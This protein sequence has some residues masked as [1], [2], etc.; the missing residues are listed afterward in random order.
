MN[1]E[2][3]H[4]KKVLFEFLQKEAGLQIYLTGDLDDFFW[5]KT[6]WYAL[7]ENDEIKSV[8][9]LYSGMMPPTLLCFQRKDPE[10]A[11]LLLKEI[12]PLLPCRF[13]AHLG[14]GFADVFGSE[15]I[16]E[17]YGVNYKMV[18]HK[19]IHFEIVND[20][21][22]LGIN[23]LPRLL[24]LYSV[25]YPNNWFD[26][27]MLESGKYL[28]YFI[29]DELI[30]VAGIHVYSAK[31]KVAAL[32]NITT[33]PAFRQ[34]GIGIKITAA[35]CADLQQSVDVIGL[36]VRS[37]NACAIRL[38]E[39]LGFEIEGKYMECLVGNK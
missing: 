28:G 35:L 30:A 4:N 10:S 2:L 29:E 36:N 20:V 22:R 34:Q 21:R 13:Y 15:N 27:R 33:H 19:K 5:P 12:K 11:M 6:S 7:K 8:A 24:K 3:V 25:A 18:L 9:L 26:N 16:V 23:D 17:H 38:Y 31:Y 1:V 39:N 32:G 37:D 14:N